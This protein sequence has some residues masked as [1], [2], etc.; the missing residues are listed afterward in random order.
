MESFIFCAVPLVN[1]TKN[2]GAYIHEKLQLKHGKQS[3]PA[4]ICQTYI[5]C[6][7]YNMSSF[8]KTVVR[9]FETGIKRLYSNHKKNLATNLFNLVHL[10]D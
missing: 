2:S 10:P 7:I 9:A 5:I 6:Q 8:S 4:K 3:A 1:D